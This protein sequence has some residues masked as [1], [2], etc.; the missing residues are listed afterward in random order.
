MSFNK[1]EK[2]KLTE[3][4]KQHSYVEITKILGISDSTLTYWLKKL[5]LKCKPTKAK[6]EEVDAI[7]T[8]EYL[9]EEYINKN[10]K[11]EDIAN[12]VGASRD[13]V[14]RRLKRYGL[15]KVAKKIGCNTSSKKDIL[16]REYLEEVYDKLEVKEI[17]KLNGVA[18]S[19]VRKYLYKYSLPVKKQSIR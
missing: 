18:P 10:R 17:A 13:T 7:L 15:Y 14:Q 9:Q 5:D 2:E 3:L 6:S 19:T 8:K 12:E 11:L 4:C 16:T 1:V